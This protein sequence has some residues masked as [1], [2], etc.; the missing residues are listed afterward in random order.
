[1]DL[2]QISSMAY[3][4]HRA[5]GMLLRSIQYYMLFS[6]L[7]AIQSDASRLRALR[8]SRVFSA[9]MAVTEMATLK[10][11]QDGRE[12]DLHLRVED[13]PLRISEMYL[14]RV[15]EELLENAFRNS[16]S[17]SAVEVTGEV[18]M[19]WQEY[20]LRVCH[21]GRGML[22]EQVALLMGRGVPGSLSSDYIGQGVGLMIV[23]RLV[24]LH[25]GAFSIESQPKQST[26]IEIRIPLS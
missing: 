26:T 20:L 6:E 14:Q 16:P 4:I 18:H 24:E 23:K 22:P 13:S 17:G 25:Q 19:D 7:E 5:A 9:W 12:A 2:G 3:E 11:R 10:A 15:V 1:L 21:H 8:D